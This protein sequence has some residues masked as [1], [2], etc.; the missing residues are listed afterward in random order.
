MLRFREGDRVRVL[1]NSGHWEGVLATVTATSAVR[2]LEGH[3]VP[4]GIWTVFDYKIAP[5]C[6]GA[7][8]LIDLLNEEALEDAE[9]NSREN[10]RLLPI[11]PG[12]TIPITEE[13]GLGA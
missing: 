2:L 5:D 11:D 7:A 12:Q 1:D 9:E 3:S 10:L 8:C 13:F 4:H 6:C